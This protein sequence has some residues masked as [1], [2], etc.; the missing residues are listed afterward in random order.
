MPHLPE[1]CC[2]ACSL[3]SLT[4]PASRLQW[5]ELP[6]PRWALIRRARRDIK[7]GLYDHGDVVDSKIDHCI[8]MI[9]ADVEDTYNAA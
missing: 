6:Q 8:D 3:S 4:R 1:D 5:E 7:A 2:D 9:L